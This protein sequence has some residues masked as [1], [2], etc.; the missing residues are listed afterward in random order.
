MAKRLALVFLALAPPV[1]LIT[2]M[3]GTPVGETVFAI[4][5]ILFPIALTMLG[6]QRRGSLG[7][8][9]WPFAIWA[10]LLVGGVVVMLQTRGQILEVPWFGGLPLPAA[11]QFYIV[12]LIPFFIVSLAYGL[13]FDRFG[14]RE[15]DLETLRRRFK[16]DD[17]GGH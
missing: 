2:F 11:V 10:L 3:V 4:L 16:K 7:P 12:F 13:T 17:Q 15:E 14:L 5:G 8:L 1:M 9:K 6:A